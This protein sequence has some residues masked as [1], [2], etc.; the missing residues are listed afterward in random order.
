MDMLQYYGEG[1]RYHEAVRWG[2]IL[3][4]SGLTATDAGETVEQQAEAVLKKADSVLEKYGSDR[5][6]VPRAEIF[7]R[8][9]EDVTRFNQVWDRWI[10]QETAPARYLA[11]SQLGREEILVE[12]VLTA[13]VG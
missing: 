8:R 1:G 11:V 12:V 10:H 6:H 3:F 9:A 4:F 5:D 2:E 13:V 7:I